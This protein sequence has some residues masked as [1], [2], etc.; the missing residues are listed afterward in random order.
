MLHWIL[1]LEAISTNLHDGRRNFVLGLELFKAH[2]FDPCKYLK[3]TPVAL[4]NE[5]TEKK[6]Y[7][8]L[9]L[10]ALGWNL[11]DKRNPLAQELRTSS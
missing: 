1:I 4:L 10:E 9:H 11:E 8:Q 2:Y 3:S 5:V 6:S 7:P